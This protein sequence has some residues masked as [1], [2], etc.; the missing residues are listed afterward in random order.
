MSDYPNC[1]VLADDYSKTSSNRNNESSKSK[2]DDIIGQVQTSG[3][4]IR[5][6]KD[7]S[8]Q[9][10]LFVTSEKKISNKSSLNRCLVFPMDTPFDEDEMTWL[11]RNKS[12]FLSFI[13]DFIMYLLVEDD[14]IRDRVETYRIICESEG[15]KY[16]E[17][18]AVNPRTIRNKETLE[19]TLLLLK[20]FLGNKLHIHEDNLRNLDNK[21]RESIDTCISNT[22]C[23]LKENDDKQGTEYF[24][25]LVYLCV[26]PQFIRGTDSMKV[27]KTSMKAANSN[28]GSLPNYIF[29]YDK[30]EN[31]CCIKSNVLLRYLLEE[32][33][34]E[35]PPTEKAV[36]KQL[37]YLDVI[38]RP[39][40]EFTRNPK[41]ESTYKISGYESMGRFLHIRCSELI[42]REKELLEKMGNNT[43]VPEIGYHTL[44]EAYG[45]DD[46]DDYEGLF[47][48][49]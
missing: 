21:F 31:C 16:R 8:I 14:V 26:S 24:D 7:C 32:G 34:F 6:N 19:I 27:F 1:P 40:S 44:E 42:N 11:Q 20:D 45:S 41:S 15:K 3:R 4:V 35:K 18:H 37:K 39:G 29:Y 22:L 23:Y 5:D 25:Y 30:K 38:R 48:S 46:D 43:F 33:K 10:I 28:S 12:L 17:K 9:S 2:V 49:D 47:N 13:Y 36:I